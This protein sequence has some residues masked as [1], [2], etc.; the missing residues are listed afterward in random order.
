MLDVYYV[1]AH[2]LA[3][4]LKEARRAA[5]L[6]QQQLATAAKIGQ[7]VIS[8]IEAGRVKKPAHADVVRICRVLGVDPQ[9]ID[10]FRVNGGK[11]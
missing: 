4:T 2:N 3:M 1:N 6:T 9:S 5:K 10:E 8:Q 7:P 11:S